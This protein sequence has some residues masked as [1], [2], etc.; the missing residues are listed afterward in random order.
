M[1]D[2]P[3]N[4]DTINKTIDVIDESTKETRKEID[5]GAAKGINKL[6]K[7]FD[8]SIIGRKVDVYIAERPY[9]LDK[10]LKKMRAKYDSIPSEYQVE[11]SSFIALHGV[12]ELNYSLDEEHLKKMFENLLISDMD[13]RKK[14]RVLPSYIEIIKQLSKEDALLLQFLKE[15]QIMNDPIIKIKYIIDDKGNFTY[16]SNNLFLVT[17]NNYK[18]LNSIVIDNLLRL[19]I[20]N[21]SFDLHRSD[22]NI[23]SKCFSQIKDSTLFQKLPNGAKELGHSDGIIQITDFGKNFMNIC[24]S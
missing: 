9:K 22:E 16:A 23:Y 8:A 21:I 19:N 14:G 5:K 3:I 15:N 20:V 4:T 13:A 6:F 11:P 2:L 10:E 24:L 7:L 1:N 18:I 17:N 12:E